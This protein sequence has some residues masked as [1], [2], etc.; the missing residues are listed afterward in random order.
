MN[1]NHYRK[2]ANLTQEQLAEKLLVDRSAIAKWET[3]KA[4]PTTDKLITLAEILDCTTDE[5]LKESEG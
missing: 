1:L 2:R 5:L 3:G 4:N